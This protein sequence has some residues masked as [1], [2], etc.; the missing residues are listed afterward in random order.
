MLVAA[1][2]MLD[3]L[4]KYRDERYEELYE[5][6]LIKNVEHTSGI[7]Y[8]FGYAPQHRYYGYTFFAETDDFWLQTLQKDRV[9]DI[10][11]EDVRQWV[12]SQ[13]YYPDAVNNAD[14]HSEQNL[15]NQFVTYHLLPCRLPVEKVG[16]FGLEKGV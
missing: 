13:G 9:E 11:V 15:L 2:G 14:Y 1:V 3:T 7:G 8:T 4:Y 16:D 5:A 6:G 12:A 10:T